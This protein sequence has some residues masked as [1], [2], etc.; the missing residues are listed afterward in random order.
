MYQRAT[1]TV[2]PGGPPLCFF[3]EANPQ[4]SV[5]QHLTQKQITKQTHRKPPLFAFP[6]TKAGEFSCFTGG[7]PRPVMNPPQVEWNSS[8][9]RGRAN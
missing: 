1:R 3:E 8:A 4:V 5:N 2:T 6:D 9:V 7:G